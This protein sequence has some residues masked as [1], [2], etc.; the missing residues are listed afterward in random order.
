MKFLNYKIES[1]KHVY[2]TGKLSKNLK[3]TNT[4]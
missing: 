3:D 2:R 4:Y 1:V